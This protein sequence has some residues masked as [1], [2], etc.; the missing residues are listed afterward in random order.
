MELR[1]G[2]RRR[3]EAHHFANFCGEVEVQ[4]LGSRVPVLADGEAVDLF[5][6]QICELHR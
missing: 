4:I 2:A 3:R 5:L 6:G 1:S